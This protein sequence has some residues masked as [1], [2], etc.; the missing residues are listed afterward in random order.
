MM[1]MSANVRRLVELSAPLWAGEAEV[2]R[3]YW[4]S[5]VRTGETDL[6]WLGRQCSK[7]FNGTGIGEFKNLGIFLGPLTELSE[8]FPKIDA[9]TD[10]GINRRYAAELIDMLKDEFSHYMAFADVHDAIREAGEPALDPHA[11]QTWDEDVALTALRHRHNAEHG[12]L[13]VRASRFTEGGYCTL[14]REGMRLKGRGGSDDLI[15]AACAKV[16]DDEF[17][18]MLEGIAGLDDEGWSD[19]EFRLMGEL[20]IAQLRLRIHMRNAEFSFPL[21]EKRI[22]AIFDGDIEPETF[23]FERAEEALA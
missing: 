6:L 8:I 2:V 11:L 10:A 14:F 9:G 17:G 4:D 7:E 19:D 5:P 21:T 18:H 15:A 16:F 3:T 12:A 13:G 23:D 1:S 22:Q 20:V